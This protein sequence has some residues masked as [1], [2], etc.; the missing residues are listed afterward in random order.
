[1]PVYLSTTEIKDATAALWA[2]LNLKYTKSINT[3]V[4]NSERER[5]QFLT[6]IDPDPSVTSRRVHPSSFPTV[7]FG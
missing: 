5:H 1:M 7:P 4:G 2:A 3:F 6:W